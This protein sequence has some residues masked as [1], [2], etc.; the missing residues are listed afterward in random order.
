MSTRIL[1][2]D[3]HRIMREGLRAL[4]GN[5]ASIAVVGEAEDGRKAVELAAR[6]RPDI[7][8]MDLTMPGLNGIEATRQIV[9][10]NP[11]TKVIA[12]SIHSDRRFVQQMFEAGATG[13]LLKEGAFEELA[14]AIHTVADGKAFV[15]PG[16]AGILIDDLVRHLA[17]RG[18]QAGAPVLSGREKEVLQLMAEG[19][20]TKEIA[21]ILQ[22]G[23]KTVETHR[24]QIMLK[25]QL[26]S[27][28]ELTKYAIREGLTSL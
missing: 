27:V 23:A 12:L 22:V 21:V 15:S 26:D 14:R 10:A 4:L 3:D 28:A 19:K 7:V 16:I 1:I 5:Q 25:L 9:A 13:Y 8:I 6:L 18:S 24:R 17:G 20:S 11:G 2:A